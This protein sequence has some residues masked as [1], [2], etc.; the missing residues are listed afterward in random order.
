MTLHTMSQ[1]CAHTDALLHGAGLRGAVPRKHKTLKR[2]NNNKNKRFKMLHRIEPD[3]VSLGRVGA[4]IPAAQDASA[5][6][7]LHAAGGAGRA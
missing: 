1:G 2:F 7:A 6:C 3:L 4:A 5:Q